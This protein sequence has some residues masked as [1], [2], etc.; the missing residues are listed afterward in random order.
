M[1]TAKL[2][3]TKVSVGC[4][5]IGLGTSAVCA[6]S[7]HRFKLKGATSKPTGIRSLN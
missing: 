3:Y 7:A 4:Q 5:A 1:E 2:L 6:H